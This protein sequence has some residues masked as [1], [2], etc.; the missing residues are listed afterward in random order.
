MAIPV[1]ARK[2]IPERYPSKEYFLITLGSDV[3]KFIVIGKFLGT[4]SNFVKEIY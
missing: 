1:K 2:R 4:E 3:R